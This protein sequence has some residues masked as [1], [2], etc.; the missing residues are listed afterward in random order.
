VRSTSFSSSFSSSRSRIALVV[1]ATAAALAGLLQAGPP[2][3]ADALG[4]SLQVDQPSSYDAQS[5]CTAAPR[6]GTLAL[7][8][9]LLRA[10]PT[11]HSMGMMRGCAVGGRSE[12][13]DG[14]AFDWGADVAKASTRTA[15]Y[16]FIHKLLATDAEGNEHALARRMGI[17]YFIYNDTIW[18]SYRDF[19]PRAYLNAGCSSK[20]TCSRTLR[21]LNHVH[22]SLG[23][24]G[25]AAQTS[26]Y[27]ERNVPAQPVFF[28]GTHEL[29]P[30]GTAVTGFTVPATGALT[31]SPFLLRAGVTYRVVA[32]GAVRLDANTLGDANCV[33]TPAGYVPT[34]RGPV[35]GTAIPDPIDPGGGWSGGW[36]GGGWGGEN[37][38][39]DHA[40]SPYALPLPTT[41][42]L[43]LTT[44]LRWE[45]DCTLTHTYEA[46][47]TPKSTQRL[48]LRYADAAP[49][50][51]SG[52]FKV[53]VARDDIILDSLKK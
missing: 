4:L 16:G 25:A 26:W 32:T 36:D 45:G 21:H 9:Y 23:F 18:A 19:A 44:A 12:H 14:R 52:S 35:L 28:A 2:P 10:F 43:L 46:W 15:A 33:H 49:S 6:P 5:T 20:A 38:G 31:S 37:T 8:H 53:Y 50:D 34:D 11:T 22:I 24:A 42:G 39:S 27:R 13:K 29:D 1:V 17:M 3:R 47:F 41:H 7:A 48:Y 30:T 51:N 40:D